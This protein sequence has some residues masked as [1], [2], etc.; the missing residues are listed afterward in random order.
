MNTTNNTK[1]TLMAAALAVTGLTATV[2]TAQM[3]DTTPAAPRANESGLDQAGQTAKNAGNAAVDGVK[4][5][6]TDTKQAVTG[7]VDGTDN[8]VPADKDRNE[9]ALGVLETST[10]AAVTEDGFDDLVERFVD[11]DR[12]RIGASMPTAD[13]ITK[14]NQVTADIRTAWQAKYGSEFDINKRT[15]VFNSSYAVKYGEV[16]QGSARTAGQTMTPT[17]PG[18]AAGESPVN[19]PQPNGVMGGEMNGG[20]TPQDRAGT[21]TPPP[22]S[23]DPNA[24]REPGRDIATITTPK[25]GDLKSMQVPL[26]WEFPGVYKIDVPDSVNGKTLYDSLY[27]NLKAV[28]DGKAEWPADEQAAYRAVSARVLNA[29][30]NAGS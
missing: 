13:Q 24:N 10:E 20:A 1:L 17:T 11:A 3:T 22:A 30:F 19:P 4:N 26:I 2:A 14:L 27:K 12:N 8:G 23:N 9:N 21:A 15:T 7:A 18:T 28:D 29:M 25:V 16:G 5:A 6:A